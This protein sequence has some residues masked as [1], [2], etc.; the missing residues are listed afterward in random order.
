MPS[1]AA[2]RTTG[3]LAEGLLQYRRMLCSFIYSL[4]RDVVVTEEIYQ[5][6]ALVALEKDRKG[7]EEIREVGQWLRETAWR[8]VQAGFRTRQGKVVTVDPEYLEQVAEVFES[9][10]TPTYQQDRLEALDRCLKRVSSENRAVLHRHYVD[11]MRYED[12]AASVQ[13]KPGALRV[14]VH[15]VV[16]Q[17]LTCIENR[18]ASE[19]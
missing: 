14:L 4:V 17:L 16:R 12:I 11:G 18:L 6:V 3:S 19:P 8:L 15:R 13:R 7:D 9:R 1:Q 5:Q 2:E 10:A